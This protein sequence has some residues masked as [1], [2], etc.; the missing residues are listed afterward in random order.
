MYSKSQLAFK[1]FQYA[2]KASNGRGH[3]IHSPFVYEFVRHVL[4]DKRSYPAYE[5]IEQVRKSL[6]SDKRKLPLSDF[7]AGSASGNMGT[8]TISS[9]AAT[10]LSSGKFGRL[11]FRLARHYHAAKIIELGS[12]LGISTAYLASGNSSSHVTTMEGS[13]AI[14]RI[15]TETFERLDLKNISQL[16]GNFDE[17]LTRLISTNPPADLV[18]I[19]GNH[20]K[21]PVLEYFDAFLNKTSPASLIVVHDIHWSAEMEEAWTIIRGHPGVKMSIDLFS[22]GLIFFREEFKVKQEFIIRF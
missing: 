3:G 15:A 6:L 7:G 21:K 16:T 5:Q 10:A 4:L 18:F 20:R 11:L 17:G 13:P 22:A 8:K 2:I 14:A 19:D 9:I 12:S 1:W